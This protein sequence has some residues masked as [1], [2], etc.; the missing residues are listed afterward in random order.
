MRNGTDVAVTKVW[1]PATALRWKRSMGKTGGGTAFW[2]HQCRMVTS[3]QRKLRA[4]PIGCSRVPF[5][6]GAATKEQ[7]NKK[8]M[9]VIENPTKS[10]VQ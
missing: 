10:V 9:I 6:G 7:M 1:Q 4:F 3:E 8:L 2:P 5:S